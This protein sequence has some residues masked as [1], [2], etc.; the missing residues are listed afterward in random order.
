MDKPHK[1]LHA[2]SASL[3]LAVVVYRTTDA[4]PKREQYTLADQ[5]RRCV[6]SVPSN[7]AEGA[8]RQSKKEFLHFLHIAKG[9]LSELDTQV[10]LAK[11][12]GYLSTAVWTNLNSR[13]TT[14]D[15]ML[16][17]LVRHLKSSTK[18]TV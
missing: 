10:E 7:I 15:K 17:G 3:D 13:M 11:Q 8:A 12:L 1:R 5:M 2:W 18:G 14:I 9:S 4:F 16:S 6:L